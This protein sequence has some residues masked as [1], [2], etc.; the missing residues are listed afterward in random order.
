MAT[1]IILVDIIPY[2]IMYSFE[3]YI[4]GIN[5]YKLN[6]L[7][8]GKSSSSALRYNHI[9]K[10]VRIIIFFITV[11]GRE[12]RCIEKIP[13][14]HCIIGIINSL[15]LLKYVKMK[16]KINKCH[17]TTSSITAHIAL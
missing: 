8:R 12:K 7:K 14:N 4:I 13:N 10:V 15:Y 6:R 5:M 3:F 9:F 11:S 1:L 16:I 17:N 2:Q